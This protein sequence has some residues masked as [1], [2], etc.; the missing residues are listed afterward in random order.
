LTITATAWDDAGRDGYVKVSAK[1]D[2]A[3]HALIEMADAAP[4]LVK[5][6]SIAQRHLLSR[7]YLEAT[8]G[9]LRRAGLVRSRRG[10]NGG[11]ALALAPGQITVAAIFHALNGP[12][13]EMAPSRSP[14]MWLTIDTS[15]RRALNETTLAH[16][17]AATRDPIESQTPA[18][19]PG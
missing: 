10:P 7:K 4:E 6:E 8:L 14:R 18:R 15:L 1:T 11:Y 5:V 13:I 9:D 3:L 19:D 2:Y 12:L 17:L 16:L